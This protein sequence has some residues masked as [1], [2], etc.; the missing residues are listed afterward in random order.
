MAGVSPAC[1]FVSGGE[2]FIEICAADGSLKK[3]KVSNEFNPLSTQNKGGDTQSTQHKYNNKNCNFC[4][5]NSQ[6]SKE[7]SENTLIKIYT[8]N[9]YTIIDTN[10][11]Y[12]KPYINNNSQPRAPPTTFA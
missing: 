11:H 5:A 8:N 9:I 4:F 3:I 2:N 12:H 7:P 1:A 6:I 10:N